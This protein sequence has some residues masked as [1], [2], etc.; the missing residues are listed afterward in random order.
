M[1]SAPRQPSSREW[2]VDDGPPL[3]LFN[4]DLQPNGGKVLYVNASKL[5]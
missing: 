5:S 1:S 2:S 4:I 3:T